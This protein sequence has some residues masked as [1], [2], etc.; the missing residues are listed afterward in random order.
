LQRTRLETID[1]QIVAL[2]QK[3]TDTKGDDTVSSQLATFENLELDEKFTERMYT[4][5]QAA[6]EKA[7]QERER[8]LLYLIVVVRPTMPE[9]ATYPQVPLTTSLV[10]SSLLVIWGIGALLTA[11]IKDQAV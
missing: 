8:Q 10:F 11:A 9:S 1:K 7:R 5:A 4:V 3:L 6:Y 2:Q